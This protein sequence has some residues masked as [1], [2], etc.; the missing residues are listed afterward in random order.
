LFFFDPPVRED[1]SELLVSVHAPET[2]AALAGLTGAEPNSSLGMALV[3]IYDCFGAAVEG[4]RVTAENVGGVAKTFYVRNGLPATTASFT[5]ETGYSGFV[6]ATP[7]TATF[8]A[9]TDDL[10]IGSVTVQVQ[11][12]AQTI[13]YIVPHGT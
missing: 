13:A 4:V 9:S 2:A 1:R 12:G 6:N 5:D 10:Y 8:S 7:G 11:A 3:T